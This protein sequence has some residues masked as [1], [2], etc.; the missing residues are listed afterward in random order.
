MFQSVK[1]EA[2][3][4][5]VGEIQLCLLFW[6]ACWQRSIFPSR[7]LQSFKFQS[8]PIH[9]FCSLQLPFSSANGP[10]KL[11]WSGI[12]RIL[13]SSHLNLVIWCYLV[14]P[15]IHIHILWS[16]QRFPFSSHVNFTS[17]GDPQAAWLW[18]W[19]YGS[20]ETREKWRRFTIHLLVNQ[21]GC[22][23]KWKT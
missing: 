1:C 21:W 22:G 18:P 2:V 10:L 23:S 15:H 6:Y 12:F 16:P 7:I 8:G 4:E 5:T 14:I 20:P 3:R 9:R 11:E 19:P 17:H 13:W